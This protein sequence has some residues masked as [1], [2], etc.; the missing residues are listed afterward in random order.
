MDP[1]RAYAIAAGGLF[2]LILLY[3]L[4]TRI[5][6]FI[7]SR[8]VFFLLKHFIYPYVFRRHRFMEL[9]TR[10]QFI[11]QVV[12]WCATAA[13]NFIRVNT[14]AQASARA[15]TLSVINLIPLLFA[16]KLSIAADLFGVSLRGFYGLHRSVGFMVVVQGLVHISILLKEKMVSVHAPYQ[17][18]GILVRF[19]AYSLV[20]SLPY[21]RVQAL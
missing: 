4:T 18:Y 6:S 20:Q 21:I 19:R 5:L 16:G 2:L 11:L 12:Y 10:E 8:T 13:C 14:M 7:R 1:S 9:V 15:G 3:R 17:I